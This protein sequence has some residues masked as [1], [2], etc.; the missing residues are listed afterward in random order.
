MTNWKKAFE[1]E[2]QMAADARERG[3]EGRARVCARRA[4]GVVIREDFLRRGLSCRTSSAY[5]LLRALLD[6]PEIPDEARRAAGH[7]TLR[8]TE[9]FKF[10]VA[11]DLVEAARTLCKSLLPGEFEQ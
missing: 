2:L 8:V 3:N 10:P 7:L 4:A 5:D 6:L 11:V 1:K 9:E